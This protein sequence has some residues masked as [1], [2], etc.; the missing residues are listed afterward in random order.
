MGFL[1]LQIAVLWMAVMEARVRTV[2]CSDTVLAVSDVLPV[3][4]LKNSGCV[5]TL[6]LPYM[7]A[8]ALL[9]L[10][11]HQVAHRQV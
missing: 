10:P 6:I 8:S 7:H 5:Q 2:N 1:L 3:L 9:S 4:H 11:K